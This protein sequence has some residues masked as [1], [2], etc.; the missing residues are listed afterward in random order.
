MPGEA[1]GRLFGR[2]GAAPGRI[3]TTKGCVETELRTPEPGDEVYELTLDGAG[4][5]LD[6]LVNVGVGSKVNV[7]HRRLASPAGSC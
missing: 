1:L 7:L 4:S 5:G 3:D 6:V 2:Q